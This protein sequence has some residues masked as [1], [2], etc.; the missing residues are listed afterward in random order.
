MKKNCHLVF[1]ENSSSIVYTNP[2]SP[3]R[4]I[5]RQNCDMFASEEALEFDFFKELDFFLRNSISCV[6]EFVRVNEELRSENSFLG[7][8]VRYLVA[9]RPEL[10]TNMWICF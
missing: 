3:T 4:L 6:F 8:E 2:N 9:I 10:V 1:T 5:S 7:H